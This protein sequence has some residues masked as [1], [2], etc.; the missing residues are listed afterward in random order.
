MYVYNLKHRDENDNLPLG[1]HNIGTDCS[2][3][4]TEKFFWIKF[5]MNKIYWNNHIHLI[6][7]MYI[8]VVL[9]YYGLLVHADSTYWDALGKEKENNF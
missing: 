5:H 4:S 1:T 9:Y 8:G 7:S 2:I 6:L 3:L